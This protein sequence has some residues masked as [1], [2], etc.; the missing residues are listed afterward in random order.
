MSKEQRQ[1]AHRSG[2]GIDPMTRQLFTVR[3]GDNWY[4]VDIE[5][6][7]TVFNAMTLTPVPLAPKAIAGLVN[8]RG[9]VLTAIDLHSFLHI[10]KI[11][12]RKRYLLVGISHK[13][14][15]FGLIIDAAGDIID[16]KDEDR[17]FVPTTP[18]QRSSQPSMTTY[19]NGSRLIPVLDIQNI[20][21][22]IGA[23]VISSAA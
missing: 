3:L 14:E 17:V 8:V 15:D 9:E 5:K 10:P 7:R 4:G 20:L 18:E 22:A 2:P 11:A 19:R 6:V 23:S 1:F 13:A 16:V 12:E 21:V